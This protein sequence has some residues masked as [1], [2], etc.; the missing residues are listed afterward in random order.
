M[1]ALIIA[2]VAIIGSTAI[3]GAQLRQSPIDTGKKVVCV[4]NSTCHNREGQYFNDSIF[5]RLLLFQSQI[6]IFEECEQN[7]NK[8]A[9]IN[10]FIVRLKVS[11]VMRLL[12]CRKLY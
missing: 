7:I 5:F 1:K 2:F 8:L 9:R 4:Y 10:S 6:N 3:V 11:I 12:R